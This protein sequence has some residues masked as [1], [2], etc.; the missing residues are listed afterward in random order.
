MGESEAPPSL[1]EGV[2]PPVTTPRDVVGLNLNRAYTSSLAMRWVPM[3]FGG[4]SSGNGGVTRG[5]FI[6]N[7]GSN[8]VAPEV[9]DKT[10]G[11]QYDDDE[12]RMSSFFVLSLL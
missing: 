8:R 9:F 7:I 1:A 2:F 4:T 12:V 10:T 5:I 3:Q 11:A 6:H